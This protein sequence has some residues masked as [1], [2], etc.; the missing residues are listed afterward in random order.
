MKKFSILILL[1]ASLTL[2]VS[3]IDNDSIEVEGIITQKFTRDGAYFFNVEYEL[4]L[5]ESP[6]F[7]TT[8]EIKVSRSTYDSYL[9]GDSYTFKR[10]APK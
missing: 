2:L 8:T 10:P 9:T 6:P 3:C 4:I 1:F 7:M 5:E